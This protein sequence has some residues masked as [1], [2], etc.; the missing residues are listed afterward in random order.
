METILITV[1][2]QG[3]INGCV[4]HTTKQEVKVDISNPKDKFPKFIN[5]KILHTDRGSNP[6]VKKIKI[7]ENILSGWLHGE[8]PSWEKPS[9]WKVMNKKQRLES[10]VNRFDEGFGVS[11]Q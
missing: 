2:L 8:C 10:Y 7:N 9:K 11:Y 5:K 3:R 6:C 1:K 4:K